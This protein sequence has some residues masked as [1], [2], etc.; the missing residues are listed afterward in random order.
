MPIHSSDPTVPL[1]YRGISLLFV[2]YKI[3]TYILNKRLSEWLEENE[4]LCENQNELRQKEVQWTIYL[5]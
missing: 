3:F 4:I 1:N 5:Q 2:P